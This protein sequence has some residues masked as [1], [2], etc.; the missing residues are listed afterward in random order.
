MLEHGIRTRDKIDAWYQWAATLTVMRT[1]RYHRPHRL[2]H[3]FQ[4]YIR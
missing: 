1:T 4:E 3:A 2:R